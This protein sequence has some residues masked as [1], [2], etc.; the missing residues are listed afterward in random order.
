MTIRKKVLLGY[1]SLIIC[2]LLASSIALFLMNK[3]EGKAEEIDANWMP[4]VLVLGSLSENISNLP[5]VISE[6]GLESKIERISQLEIEANTILKE[7]ER[8]QKIYEPLISSDAEKQLYHIF[9]DSWEVYKEKIPHVLQIARD[10]DSAKTIAAI[11]DTFS[12]WNKANEGIKD[13]VALN[14]KGASEATVGAVSLNQTGLTIVILISLLALIIGVVLALITMRDIKRVTQQIQ[15]SSG[16]VASSSEEISASIEEVASGSQH[17]AASVALVSDM[18]EQMNQAIN[19]TAVN[20][21]QTNEFVNKTVTV[22]YSGGE[23]M[24][25]SIDGMKDITAKVDELLTNSQRIDR[26]TSSIQDIANQTNLLAL[27]ASI[28]AAR[29][30]EHGRGF[31]V[32]ASEVGKLAKQSSTATKEIIDLISEMQTSTQKTVETVGNGS[33]LVS[34]AYQS[35]DEIVRFV[36]ETSSRIAE[37]AASCE[38]QSAQIAEV[39]KA[40]QNIAAVTEETSASTEETSNAVVDLAKMAENLNQLVAKF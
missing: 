15:H 11:N 12:H 10:N 22:A 27:N 30:G 25:N 23:M 5:A 29:A 33:A 9:L 14:G 13:L 2:L 32:V 40:A 4:S 39:L 19:Q 1:A 34:Q 18:I 6:I 36:K 28:E 21:E 31:A 37:V 38:E 35:F 20:I 16:S 24:E 17:Q 7:I 8:D 26:I 3:I